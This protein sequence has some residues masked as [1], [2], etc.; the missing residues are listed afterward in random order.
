MGGG[1]EGVSE[2]T[3]RARAPGRKMNR[4][5]SVVTDGVLYVTGLG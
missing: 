5:Q 1:D 2:G 3:D 4:R